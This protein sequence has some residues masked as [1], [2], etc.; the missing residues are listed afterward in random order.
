MP[1]GFVYALEL[2]TGIIKVGRTDDWERRLGEHT[3]DCLK[4]GVT[5]TRHAHVLVADAE[6]AEEDLIRAIGRQLSRT[7]AGR[8][9]FQGDFAVARRALSTFGQVRGDE[10]TV[11]IGVTFNEVS[12]ARYINRLDVAWIVDRVSDISEDVDEFEVFCDGPDV[13]TVMGA[14]EVAKGWELAESRS[15]D[16]WLSRKLEDENAFEEEFDEERA[17]GDTVLRYRRDG[18]PRP[19]PPFNVRWVR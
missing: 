13:D 16:E 19:V 4:R 14:I 18:S 8:E 6:G 11:V 15:F 12:S 3:R 5:I 1:A 17:A 7:G 2:S 9:Y 10:A